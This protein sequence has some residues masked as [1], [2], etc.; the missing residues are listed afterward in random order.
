MER[1][2]DQ[3]IAK[4]TSDPATG[5]YG[6]YLV[7]WFGE[8]ET[9]LSPSGARPATSEELRERL[10]GTLSDEEARKIEVCVIDVSKPT[11]T[12]P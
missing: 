9:K 2:R 1:L 3:L 7:L 11:S 5:G 4:Y 10:A 8:G 6:I 12:A